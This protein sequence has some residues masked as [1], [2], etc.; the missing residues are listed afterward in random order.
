M[1]RPFPFIYGA[2]PVLLRGLS[3]SFTGPVPFFYGSHKARLA[4][5]ECL[6]L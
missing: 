6:L 4:F 2:C 5:S 1:D 3:R